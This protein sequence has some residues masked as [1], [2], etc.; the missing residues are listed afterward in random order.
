[1][2]RGI[3]AGKPK[4]KS[5]SR[6]RSL[7]RD[8]YET[9]ERERVIREIKEQVT[10]E[11]TEMIMYQHNIDML[12]VLFALRDEFKFGRDR[13]VRTLKKASEHAE[14]MYREEVSV[15]DMLDILEKETGV[16]ETDLVF[17]KVVESEKGGD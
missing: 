2:G 14:N 11:F 4:K 5:S 12:S 3:K 17:E 9:K 6:L 16:T 10:D 7:V 15:D 1:M 8:I 13:L